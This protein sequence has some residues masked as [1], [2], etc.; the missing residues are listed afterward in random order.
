MIAQFGGDVNSITILL[1]FLFFAGLSSLWNSR[2]FRVIV[3]ALG[4]V[5]LIL[6]LT[7]LY[8]TQTFIGYSFFIHFNTR[9]MSGMAGLFSTQL[10]LAL[11][12]AILFFT[13]IYLA[14]P[15]VYRFIV[16][17][18][19]SAKFKNGL[20][21]LTGV[22]LIAVLITV[23]TKSP[24]LK[25]SQTLLTLLETNT[26]GFQQA[27]KNVGFKD[28][29]L[30]HNLEV[31]PGK[32][33]IVLSLE[34]AEYDF[35]KGNFKHLT[36]NLNALRR[37]NR[38]IK[39]N[40]NQGSDWTSGSLYTYLTGFPA[41]FGTGGN[42]IFQN[43]YRSEMSSLLHILNKAGYQTVYYNGNT[44]HAGVTDMLTTFEIDRIV[45]INT[46]DSTGFESN[47][48]LRDFDLF[49]L[50]SHDLS[51]FGQN[52]NQPFA[53]FI[54][55]T[56]THFPNGI[57]DERLEDFVEK[58]ESD[59]EF[60]M[61]GLDH[62]VGQFITQIKDEGLLENTVF[63]IF[64]DHLKMGDPSMFPN[65]DKRSLYVICNGGKNI[66]K[67][68]TD[69]YYQIDLP[70]IIL[71]G[72]EIEHNAK[73]LTDF[74][75]GNKHEYIK[76]HLAQ[77]TEINING[78]LRTEAEIVDV[79]KVSANYDLYLQDTNRFIAHAGGMIDGRIYTNTLEALDAN[80]KKGFRLFELDILKTTDGKYVGA[81]D[82]KKWKRFTGY[83][84]ETPV[85]H[86]VF[87]NH[88]PYGTYT[89]LD[90]PG[91]NDWFN[92]HKDAV[93][94]TDKINEPL[95]FAPEF[96]DP[97]RLMMELFSEEAL[98]EGLKAGIKSAV[99][100]QWLIKDL[101]PDDAAELFDRG[102]RHAAVSRRFI[103]DNKELLAALKAAGI[104]VFVYNVN[105]D[106][107]IDEEFVLKYELDFVYGLYAD[108]HDF[109][110]T[111]E[112]EHQSNTL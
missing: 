63:Y 61:S 97:D 72:A 30:P 38:F 28:Y 95:A 20:K 41:F 8:T 16:P 50:A 58:R 45:D 105:L 77:I 5:F 33:I 52:P 4:T 47:Y 86:D 79:S 81:H 90:L 27:L 59:Y 91:I 18:L 100:S 112:E 62:L 51:R 10:W 94:V 60:M 22:F 7:S 71:D 31:K 37:K 110:F 35:L 6:Q 56:D 44:A 24:L 11:L 108:K 93:L 87:M 12:L 109:E 53:L 107:G 9:G 89:P 46:V 74:I 85:T 48:G 92:Q 84:G 17:Y 39:M 42:S 68:I 29:T 64:P 73:F 15:L 88:K 23:L 80:Y 57:Y 65:P 70:H 25:N 67:N 26:P 14:H 21:L 3:A 78:L 1:L 66:T 102:V 96:T 76:N 54:S 106:P 36:P 32:N 75:T 49:Q 43:A 111:N 83:E 103:P 2:A 99:P 34:S 69:P 98:E 19:K 55:T 40:Q 13:A 82:W 101:K 104:K